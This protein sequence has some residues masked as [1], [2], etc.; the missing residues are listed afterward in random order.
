VGRLFTGVRLPPDRA[1]RLQMA[2]RLFLEY[3]ATAAEVCVLRASPVQELM[4]TVDPAGRMSALDL[5]GSMPARALLVAAS[6]EAEARGRRAQRLARMRG[7]LARV[8]AEREEEEA[9]LRA[10]TADLPARLAEARLG[11]RRAQRRLEP[12]LLQLKYARE[13]GVA[14]EQL[15]AAEAAVTA[16][17]A[18]ARQ[19]DRQLSDVHMALCL[20]LPSFPEL[21]PLVPDAA[22]RELLPIF[23]PQRSLKM[24]SNLRPLGAAAS[25]H[26]LRYGELDGRAVVLKEYSVDAAARKSCYK[27]AALLMRLRH[28]S[29]M[30]IEAVFCDVTD[31]HPAVH[32]QLPYYKHGTLREWWEAR[33]PSNAEA[34]AAVHALAGAVAHLHA[35]GV[36]HCDIKPENILID[37]A[38][39]PRCA[40]TILGECQVSNTAHRPKYSHSHCAMINPFPPPA[41]PP[42]SLVQPPIPQTGRLRRV[43]R[44]CLAGH[45]DA[46]APRNRPLHR[47]RAAGRPKQN[48]GRGVGRV[49]ARDGAERGDPRRGAADAAA[50]CRHDQEG[51]GGSANRG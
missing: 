7:A 35:H 51:A 40:F 8:T 30:P 10:G 41:P 14:G 38:G 20:S 48:S 9:A 27:E 24:Y 12:A 45:A 1:G 5:D 25:R 34:A 21:A 32:V 46:H 6:D 39:R 15:S 50:A 4:H 28:P 23:H 13:D 2:R 22:P 29:V 26:T 43:P 33:P 16:A 3:T 19:A 11:C 47:A 18:E 37:D 42:H 31:A 49:R 44:R 17:S 36:V